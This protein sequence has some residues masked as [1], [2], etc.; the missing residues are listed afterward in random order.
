MGK[1]TKAG[2]GKGTHTRPSKEGQRLGCP[3]RPQ[4]A[5]NQ[6]NQTGRELVRERQVRRRGR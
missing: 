3:K 2:K 5:A 4:L 6:I 1:A